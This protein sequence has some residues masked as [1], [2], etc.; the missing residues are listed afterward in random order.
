VLVL[1][2]GGAS[3]LLAV[4]APGLTLADKR[5]ATELLLRSGADIAAVN[6][7]RKHLSAVKGGQLAR[8]AQPAQV[9]V[10]AISDVIGSDPAVIGSGPFSPDPTTFAE[11]WAVV[12]RH[13]LAA[14]L[15]P[16]V[17]AVLQAGLAGQRPETPKPGEACFA[18]QRYLVAAD[19]S[20]W[21]EQMRRRVQAAGC[22]C[23]VLGLA[24]QGE[25]RLVAR[26]WAERLRA[27]AAAQVPGSAPAVLLAGGELTV[28]VRG[29]GRG[30][31]NQE[32]VLA[33][34]QELAGF[35]HPF[36]CASIASDG[37]DGPSD[38]AGAWIDEHSLERARALGLDPARHLTDNDAYP[39]FARLGQLVQTGPTDTNVMDMRIGV[40][41]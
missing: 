28:T 9:V 21:L 34:L 4:A 39:F 35:E 15:P 31:R 36:W 23:R 6:T 33:L 27:L 11:A 16:A 24:E 19:N 12:E 2:S 29:R 5:A 14:A 3:A 41:F 37:V 40:L 18:S 26:A 1:L 7:V 32:F 25:A 38:A 13:G 8:L 20:A 30:G 22:T 17:L 10:L